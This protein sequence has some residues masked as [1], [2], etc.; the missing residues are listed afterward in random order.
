MGVIDLRGW[1]TT[2]LLIYRKR[3][4]KDG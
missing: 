4:E 2:P 3:G 1:E